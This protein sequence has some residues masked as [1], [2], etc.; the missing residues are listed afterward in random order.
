MI[1][2]II[3][4]LVEFQ[5]DA[6]DLCVQTLLFIITILGGFIW[7]FKFKIIGIQRCGGYL[8]YVTSNYF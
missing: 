4:P 8:F 3:Q 1:H 5:H 7:F 6:F 2:E